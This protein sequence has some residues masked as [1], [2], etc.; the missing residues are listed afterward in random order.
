[1]GGFNQARK[2]ASVHSMPTCSVC[3]KV[4]KRDHQKCSIFA[5]HRKRDYARFAILFEGLDNVDLK[6]RD[7][8]LEEYM[9]TTDMEVMLK[10]LELMRITIGPEEHARRATLEAIVIGFEINCAHSQA[11]AVTT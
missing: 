9:A 1:M 8:I 7:Q 4:S 11:N 2:S 10:F 5:K 3:G 6:A